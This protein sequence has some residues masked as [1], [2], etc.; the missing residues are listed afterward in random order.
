MTGINETQHVLTHQEGD[1]V[2]HRL[3]SGMTMGAHVTT[4]SIERTGTAEAQ[5]G[6][7]PWWVPARRGHRRVLL[8]VSPD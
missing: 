2:M 6:Y 8:M 1:T 7:T 4:S 5:A 3:V